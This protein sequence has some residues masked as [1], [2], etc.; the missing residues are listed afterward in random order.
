MGAAGSLLFLSRSG[1]PLRASAPRRALLKQW[2]SRVWLV[3]GARRPAVVPGRLA[4]PGVP[5]D[6]GDGNA[7]RS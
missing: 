4:L 1:A 6:G 7:E 5:L 2:W 3:V